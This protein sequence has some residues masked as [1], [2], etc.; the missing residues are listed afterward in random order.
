MAIFHGNVSSPEGVHIYFG[1]FPKPPFNEWI[2]QLAVRAPIWNF[3]AKARHFSSGNAGES[4]DH[5]NV[6][7]G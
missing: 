1:D 6:Y 5:L 2:S 3:Q 4:R 7:I